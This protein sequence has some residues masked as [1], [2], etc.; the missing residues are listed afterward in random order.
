MNG[1]SDSDDAPRLV[2]EIRKDQIGVVV[3]AAGRLPV[4]LWDL[5]N[6]WGWGA[7]SIELRGAGND[8]SYLI[9]RRERDWTKNGPSF[10]CLE[11]GE[12]RYIPVHLD[13]GW[14]KRG[15][16]LKALIDSPV[17]VR[18]WWRTPP[19]PEAA[20]LGVWEG[21]VAS[22]WTASNPPQK[23]LRPDVA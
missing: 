5:H 9:E 20:A 23:W 6:S 13:D 10:F 1:P 21:V 18:A 4:R 19:S 3:S 14:W 22:S 12:S 2:T 8:S 15:D 11:V 7:I 17:Q 16:A